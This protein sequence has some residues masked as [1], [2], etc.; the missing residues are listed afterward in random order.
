MTTSAKEK[1]SMK[2]TINDGGLAFPFKCQGPTT[3]PEIYYGMSLRDWFAG[4]ALQGLLAADQPCEWNLE[5]VA[6]YAYKMAD[7]MLKGR[8]K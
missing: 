5:K 6:G 1:V 7:A 3:G 4:M 8:D 2:T